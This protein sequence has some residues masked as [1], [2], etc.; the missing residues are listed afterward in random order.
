MDQSILERLA[1]ADRLAR[2]ARKAAEAGNTKRAAALRRQFDCLFDE[3]E[4]QAA[5]GRDPTRQ[6]IPAGRPEG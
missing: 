1:E 3:L 6:P 4:A 2:A 5:G